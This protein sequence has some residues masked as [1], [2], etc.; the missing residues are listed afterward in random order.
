MDF[1]HCNVKSRINLNSHPSL[2][3]TT[4]ID[5]RPPFKAFSFQPLLFGDFRV[6]SVFQTFP[7]SFTKPSNIKF[8]RTRIYGLELRKSLFN[9]LQLLYQNK[10]QKRL[11]HIFHYV[12]IFLWEFRAFLS[13]C[14]W[15]VG[16]FISFF[17]GIF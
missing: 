15:F 6:L 3:Q 4:F 16:K 8:S 7:S 1:L 14:C 5:L 12:H 13:I 9:M 10:Q 2:F 11:I 17:F